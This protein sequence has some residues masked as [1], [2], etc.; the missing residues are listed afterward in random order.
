RHRLDIPSGSGFPSLSV[1]RDAHRNRGPVPKPGTDPDECHRRLVLT[2]SPPAIASQSRLEILHNRPE[3]FEDEAVCDACN[4]LADHG[5][6]VAEQAEFV[7]ENGLYRVNR[8]VGDQIAK[9]PLPDLLSSAHRVPVRIANQ[10]ELP[11]VSGPFADPL[12]ITWSE[13]D[14]DVM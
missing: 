2:S 12:G 3:V 5:L 10:K 4:L 9:G 14:W 13:G 11:A 6:G 8:R 7:P 1:W